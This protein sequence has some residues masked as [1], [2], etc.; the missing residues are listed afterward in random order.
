M[1]QAKKD[2]G[3]NFL[4][5]ESIIVDIVNALIEEG[6]ADVVEVGP[7]MGALTKYLLKRVKGQFYAIEKDD[8]LMEYLPNAYPEIEGKLVNTDFLKFD[9][10]TLFEGKFNV[11]GNFPYNISSQILFKVLDHKE[12]VGVMV[13]MFQKEVAHRVAATPKNKAYGVITVLLQAFYDVELLFDVA[14]E[15]FDPVPKV[16]SSVIKLKRNPEKDIKST[17]KHF[18][19]VVK[20]AFSQRRKVMNNTLKMYFNQ[21]TELNEEDSSWIE[22][23]KRQRPEELSVEE[24]DR[25]VLMLEQYEV[26]N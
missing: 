23:V 7:G 10:T 25:L 1:V 24:F 12:Q 17:Y 4:Q 6:D 9:L 21:L 16:W 5:D 15:K 8:R 11:I 3:Q 2:L 13:G 19:S 20:L 18:R 22:G 14:P 26:F